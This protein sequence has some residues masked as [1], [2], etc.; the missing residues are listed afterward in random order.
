MSLETTVSELQMVLNDEIETNPCSGMCKDCDYW[1]SD[2]YLF[3][4]ER[5]WGFC[6]ISESYNGVPVRPSTLAFAVSKLSIEMRRCKYKTS[7]YHTCGQF[8]RRTT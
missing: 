4:D 3:V 8:Q 2:T 6:K 5:D 7:P 1:D